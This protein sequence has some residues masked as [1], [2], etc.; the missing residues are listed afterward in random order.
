MKSKLTCYISAPANFDLTNIENVLSNLK[1]GFHSFYDFSIGTSFSDIIKNKI[2]ESDFVISILTTESNN[3]YFELGVANGLNKPLFILIDK[4]L[5][6]PFFLEKNIYVQTNFTNLTLF[7]LAISNFVL[8]LKTKSPKLSKQKNIKNYLTIDETKKL[9]KNISHI[10]KETNRQ[11][12]EYEIFL[13]LKYIFSKLNIKSTTISDSPRSEGADI[14]IRSK[15]LSPYFGNPLFVEIGAGI[16][17]KQRLINAQ[18]KL[19]GYINNTDAKGGIILYLDINN[20]RFT[21]PSKYPNI[22]CFDLEDFVLG[23]LSEGF[24]EFIIKKRNELVHGN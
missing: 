19:S 22:L 20:K 14:L 12:I 5:K 3:V 4:E 1:I 10:R 9:I 17:N 2:R 11:K 15:E 6:V 16:L 23:I 21:F 8:D 13:L 7:E 24:E 18:D